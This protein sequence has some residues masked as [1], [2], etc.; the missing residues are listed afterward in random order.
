MNVV[1]QI[2]FGAA[3]VVLLIV[4]RSEAA[5]PEIKLPPGVVVEAQPTDASQAKIVLIA[6]STFFRP[7]EHEYIANCAVLA[8]LLRQTPG[9]FPVLA[10]DWPKQPG[11]L[12]GAKAVV[13]FFD[14]GDKHGVLKENRL[15]ELQRLIDGGVGLT[16]FHQTIDYP[17]A[18]GE[19]ARS[20]AG[21]AWEKGFS[22]RAHWIAEFTTFPSHPI[23]SG[24]APF[25]IDDGWLTKLRFV[26]GMKGITPLLRTVSPKFPSGKEPAAEAIVAWTY[27][28]PTRGRTFNFTGG[29]LHSS[30]M[31]EGYRRF[32]VNGILWSAGIEIPQAGAPVALTS[33]DLEKYLVPRATAKK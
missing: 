7:G 9:V 15:I 29:H 6:G 2:V 12:T 33:P 30:F 4:Q 14:G 28:R 8:D 23:C 22:E 19:R 17:V 20:W 3:C 11:T 16:Q 18:H 13:L 1:R 21:G 26:D 24:V 5:E 27:E 25:K 32:L 10:I 31:E